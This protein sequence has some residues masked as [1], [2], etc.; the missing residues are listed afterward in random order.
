MLDFLSLSEQLVRGLLD[1]GDAVFVV[2]L[3]ALDDGGV[4]DGRIVYSYFNVYGTNTLSIY[5]KKTENKFY[6]FKYFL[7]FTFFSKLWMT[8]T[9]KLIFTT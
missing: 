1:L 6:K 9:T 3:E 7:L 4:G 8:S 5:A 2:E